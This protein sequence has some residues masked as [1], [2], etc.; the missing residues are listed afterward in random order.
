M[1]PHLKDLL[2]F[3]PSTLK[4]LYRL[5]VLSRFQPL[6]PLLGWRSCERCGFVAR[7]LQQGGGLHGLYHV[8]PIIV[9]MD[10]GVKSTMKRM[11]FR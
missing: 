1:D 6:D 2:G 9:Y 11:V 5:F 10:P 7:S 3:A 4:P 8:V